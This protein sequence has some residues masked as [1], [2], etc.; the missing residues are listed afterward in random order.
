M[1]LEDQ[2]NSEL[3][4]CEADDLMKALREIDRLKNSNQEL[5]TK[6]GSVVKEINLLKTHLEAA[7][8]REEVLM[9]Q[10]KKLESKFVTLKEDY[11]K[12]KSQSNWNIKWVKSFE[13][14]EKIINES[15]YS[16]I[17]TG[18]RY[19]HNHKGSYL[20]KDNEDFNKTQ[21]KNESNHQLG[22]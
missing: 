11:K 10:C 7:N 9:K 14:L 12:T 5:E 8:K 13:S 16:L 15:H 18:T 19:N 22:S 1:A 21:T 4:S 2:L 3:D 17:K 6:V 20:Q